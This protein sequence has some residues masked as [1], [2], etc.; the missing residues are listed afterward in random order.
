M[1]IYK[2]NSSCLLPNAI[3][4]SASAQTLALKKG[5][6]W[7][8]TGDVGKGPTSTTGYYNGITPPAGGYTI[9]LNKASGGPSIY[10]ASNSS[11][12][13][14]LTNSIAGTSYATAA[15][16]L[17]WFSTQTDKMVTNM[18]YGSII[19]SGLQMSFDGDY[20]VSYSQDGTSNWYDMNSSIQ[21]SG[22]DA[23]NPSWANNASEITI[24]VLV[25]KTGYSTGY[26]NHPINKWNSGYNV[27]A[28]FVLYHFEDY[29]GNNADGFMQWYGYTTGNGWCGLTEG[30]G[31]FRLS[32][33]QIA[34]VCMQYKSSNGG[35]QMWVNGNKVGNR[36][37][38]SGNIGP[39]SAGY[40]TMG[41]YG[42]L[43]GGT[44]KV[45]QVLF[46]NRELSDSEMVQNYNA[47][48]SRIVTP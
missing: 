41:I 19:T 29:Q 5:N 30:Y 12:L 47:I 33:G 15:D 10:T 34:Y 32:V 9:Y 46:Y 4:Y 18:D 14:S 40:S 48:S 2:Q 38:A 31:S 13:I 11:Q 36:S 8:G 23:G 6:F 26:A 24:C 28:S 25:E 42:P 7:I 21:Y 45:H 1:G 20:T 39:N 3:K 16:C 37:G 22:G 35:G 17:N 44:S 27:N 43:G